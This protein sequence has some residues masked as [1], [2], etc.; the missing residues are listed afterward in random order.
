MFSLNPRQEAIHERA[1]RIA[2]DYLKKEFDLIEI[3]DQVESTQLFKKLNCSSLF[4]YATELL[5]LS[6]SVAY[7][8]ITIMRKSREVPEIKCIA[9]SK[10]SRIVSVIDSQNAAEWIEFASSHS[11]RDIER[12]IA[13]RFPEKV[14]YEKLKP[15]SAEMSELKL[16]VNTDF[17]TKLNRVLDME[18]QRNS[19][20]GSRV[21][22]LEAALDN[23]LFHRDPVQKANRAQTR[24]RREQR[25]TQLRPGRVPV[26]A[27]QKHLVFQRDQGQCCHRDSNGKICGRS[28]W[29][30]IHHIR[31]VELGGLND[32]DNLIT[33]CSLH[34]DLVH[35]F[36]TAN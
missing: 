17:L 22:A 6:E 8:L 30:E 25:P 11:K 16:P 5:S 4:H 2:A 21:Q 13:R 24:K 27:S 31:P 15:I 3:L 1:K 12:E 7:S 18:A 33:L 26:T 10:A 23:Y 29:I 9:I 14:Q 32:I 28:R 34:H 19:R 36:A 35:Q 20:S